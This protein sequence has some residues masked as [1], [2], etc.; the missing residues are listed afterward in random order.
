M[1]NDSQLHLILLILIPFS[2]VECQARPV[3][4]IS[5]H[6]LV[7]PSFVHFILGLVISSRSISRSQDFC[8]YICSH[9]LSLTL[10]LC[11]TSDVE[12]TV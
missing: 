12:Y 11:T 9:K 1:N 6:P 2:S 10:A 7:G 4:T 8:P 5:S 3:T